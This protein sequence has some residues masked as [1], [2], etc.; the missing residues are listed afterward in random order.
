MEAGKEK[1]RARELTGRIRRR[2]TRYRPYRPLGSLMMSLRPRHRNPRRRSHAPAPARTRSSSDVR[3]LLSHLLVLPFPVQ[4]HHRLLLL[5]LLFLLHPARVNSPSS[6]SSDSGLEIILLPP[7]PT[8]QPRTSNS[9]VGSNRHPVELGDST[10]ESFLGGEVDEAALG[11][12][13]VEDRGDGV[14]DDGLRVEESVEFVLR[15]VGGDVSTPH[16]PFRTRCG[17]RRV[18]GFSNEVGGSRGV[19]GEVGARGDGGGRAGW[20]WPRWC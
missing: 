5:L 6:L 17:S 11:S 15:R 3:H 14:W 13:D 12:G 10:L 20:D 18:V 8:H 19:V 16:D 1:A 9:L 7:H 2:L 4:H